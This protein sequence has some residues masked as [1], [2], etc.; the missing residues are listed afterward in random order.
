MFCLGD[1]ECAIEF[2]DAMELEGVKCMLEDR[3]NIENNLAELGIL[4]QEKRKKHFSRKM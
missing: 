1:G 3:I 2:S 4:G